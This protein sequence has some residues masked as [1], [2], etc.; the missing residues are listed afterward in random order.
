MSRASKL[1]ITWPFNIQIAEINLH[2]KTSKRIFLPVYRQKKLEVYSFNVNL[3]FIL[4]HRE[5]NLYFSV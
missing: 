5:E 4:I 3:N 1:Y 2:K